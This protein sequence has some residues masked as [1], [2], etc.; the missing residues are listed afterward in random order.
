M[1][2]GLVLVV[3]RSPDTSWERQRKVITKG[4]KVNISYHRLIYSR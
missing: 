2:G 1:C 4:L 3:C